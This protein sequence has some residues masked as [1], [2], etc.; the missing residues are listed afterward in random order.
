M[1]QTKKDG[2]SDDDDDDDD[3]DNNNGQGEDKT[4]FVDCIGDIGLK[5]EENDLLYI[6]GSNQP[7]LGSDFAYGKDREFD[8]LYNRFKEK[9]G[10]SEGKENTNT[11]HLNHKRMIVLVDRRQNKMDNSKH[12]TYKDNIWMYEGTYFYLENI[13]IPN[14]MQY[15]LIFSLYIA[16][17][18][19][20][21]IPPNAPGEWHI[22]A[23]KTCLLPNLK[24][25][26]GK[27]AEGD[28]LK[29]KQNGINKQQNNQ[30]SDQKDTAE[31]LRKANL[32]SGFHCKGAA[33]TVSFIVKQENAINCKLYYNGQ[34]NVF[35]PKDIHAIFPTMFNMKWNGEASGIDK[36]NEDNK[37]DNDNNEPSKNEKFLNDKRST[38][39]EE[40]NSDYPKTINDLIEEMDAKITDEH[41]TNFYNTILVSE[42]NQ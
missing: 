42:K 32:G 19:C 40:E 31:K 35:R 13:V 30:K 3:H 8:K 33:L 28:P 15:G 22:S 39:H 10:I 6:Q 29:N 14:K 1:G 38:L 11:L 5:L 37:E 24:Y 26:D 34:M 21:D 36:S 27:A 16:P 17:S 23:S 12:N 9:Y 18:N 4:D 41:F 7:S 20:R 2:V 25:G